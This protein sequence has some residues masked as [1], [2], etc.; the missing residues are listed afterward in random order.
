MAKEM[1]PRYMPKTDLQV[2]GYLVEEC[3]EVLTAAGKTI[4]WGLDSYNP[5]LP[6]EEREANRDWLMRELHDLKRAIGLVEVLCAPPDDPYSSRLHALVESAFLE[7]QEACT[8][9]WESSNSKAALKR[10]A[11][12]AER[13]LAGVS[14]LCAEDAIADAEDPHG[15]VSVADRMPERKEQEEA[16]GEFEVWTKFNNRHFAGLTDGEWRSCTKAND[17]RG[18]THWRTPTPGPKGGAS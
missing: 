10:V 4:R 12:D 6:P 3:G 5:E 2:L 1:N 17:P 16:W 9:K 14:V 13:V 18:V 11:S 15:W 7:G 8:R